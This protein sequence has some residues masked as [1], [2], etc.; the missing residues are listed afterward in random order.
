[1]HT[2]VTASFRVLSAAPPEAAA[3]Y[4][5]DYTNLPRWDPGA[6][7]VT[8]PFP[9]GDPRCFKLT[10]ARWPSLVMSYSARMEGDRVLEMRAQNEDG[11][12]TTSERIVVEQ[13]RGGCTVT[14]QLRM[15]LR[16]G[17]WLAWPLIWVLMQMEARRAAV[18]CARA[19]RALEPPR[20]LRV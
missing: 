14:Y 17:R 13:R 3:H 8:P 18:G 20:K 4:M 1:M 16:G 15:W 12:V 11:S 7:S 10:L 19:L 2:M 6:L 9:T 5:L